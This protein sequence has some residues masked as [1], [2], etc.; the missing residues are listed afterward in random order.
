MLFVLGP[1]RLMMSARQPLDSDTVLRERSSITRHQVIISWKPGKKS[2]ILDDMRIQ[3]SPIGKSSSSI[4][5]R[6]A[7]R[8]PLLFAVVLLL[9][10]GV[11]VLL[12]FSK[13][14]PPPV[15]GAT[16][17]VAAVEPGSNATVSAGRNTPA[18]GELAT[19]PPAT[20]PPPKVARE[21]P[22]GI[23]A[24]SPLALARARTL[25]T[26]L[27]QLD[28]KL[29][30]MT[31]EL[32]AAWRSQYE[33][34]KNSGADGVSAIREFLARNED[35]SFAALSGKESVGYSSLRLA[36]L[37]ALASI[38]GQTGIDGLLDVLHT[39]AL[40]AEIAQLAQHLDTLAPSQYRQE[41]LDS[42]R[43]VLTQAQTGELKDYDV[44]S[45]FQVLAKYGGADAVASFQAAG[46]KWKSYA[47]IALG[48]LPDG[49]GIP[50]LVEFAQNTSGLTSA[51]AWPM[52]AERAATSGEARNA[53]LEAVRAGTVPESAWP[54]LARAL[55]GY[56]YHISAPPATMPP[57]ISYDYSTSWHFQE[58]GEHFMAVVNV[59]N[60]SAQEINTRLTLIEQLNGLNPSDSARV[61]LATGRNALVNEL[62][63]RSK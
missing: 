45:L 34:L 16:E 35:I 40:P 50:A 63:R 32:I 18:S 57:D 44:G 46:D 41:I 27:T 58:T 23:V 56:E 26:N 22:P 28:P 25:V 20:L 21:L 13:G 1:L 52:V 61:A 17:P 7:I 14:E 15:A 49:A 51:A 11:F 36:M 9:A 6:G 19:R 33:T 53:L 4:H 10:F 3:S 60:L 31:P 39:T 37:D 47:A 43:A 24:G 54:D 30:N 38:G 29:Q 5:C 8:A 55:G 59:A 62:R 42:S 48:N 12:R 2:V